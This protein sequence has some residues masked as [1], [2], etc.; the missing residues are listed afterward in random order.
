MWWEPFDSRKQ[1]ALARS[2]AKIAL[3]TGPSPK[4]DELLINCSAKFRTWQLTFAHFLEHLAK[5]SA[6]FKKRRG[7]DKWKSLQFTDQ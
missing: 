7:Y 5:R 2:V 1:S 6:E 3:T 4:V